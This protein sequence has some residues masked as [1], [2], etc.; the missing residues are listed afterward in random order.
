MTAGTTMPSSTSIEEVRAL[1]SHQGLPIED[2]ELPQLAQLLG[3]YRAGL[4]ALGERADRQPLRASQPLP[5][6]P[7]ARLRD[8]SRGGS[9]P[10]PVAASATDRALR[11]VAAE[12]P[13][14]AFIDVV[15]SPVEPRTGPLNGL[16]FAVKDNIHVAGV[17]T[18]CGSSF[19]GREP[20]DSD[21]A[22]VAALRGA[23]A[24]YVGKT[25]LGEFAV[26]QRSPHFGEVLNPW[27]LERGAGGS[28]G[29]AAAA[30]ASG[31]V[32]L[33]LGTDSAG[34]VRIPASMCGVVGFRPSNG[35]LSLAGL[36][37]PAWT[38]DGAG[39]IA[40]N[41]ADVQRAMAVL[42]WAVLPRLD[43]GRRRKVGVLTDDSMGGVDPEVGAVYRAALERLESSD[44]ELSSISLGGLDLA[45]L[46]AAVIAYVDVASHHRETI[47]TRWRDYGAESRQLIRLG[48]LFSGVEYVCAQRARQDFLE[49]YQSMTEGLDAVITPTLPM[50][51]APSGADPSVPGEDDEIGLFAL[52]RFTA[53]A[54]VIAAPAISLPV[55]LTSDGLPVGA[56]LMAAPYHDEDLLAIAQS[57]E[58]SFAFDAVPKHRVSA[59]GC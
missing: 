3:I 5:A 47:R 11:A 15:R 7:P 22:V 17:P 29:G 34:S 12:V 24:T 35:S 57:A 20:A 13:T 39:V 31:Q 4:V 50:V 43:D 9:A 59:A 30:V 18:T 33:A 6:A 19:A 49:R 51:A 16:T 56:Q 25:N 2:R 36:V 38:V 27:D 40:G 28:S 37:G 10:A 58:R 54:N 45:P 23:G 53:L 1:C 8:P 26:T 55:G 44:L 46:A 32:D 42:D 48:H 14:N 52:I 41:V 21:A